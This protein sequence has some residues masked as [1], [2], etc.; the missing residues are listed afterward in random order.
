V[1]QVTSGDRFQSGGLKGRSDESVRRRNQPR[2]TRDL[3]HLGGYISRHHALHGDVCA[4]LSSAA[5][6]GVQF[7]AKFL[8]EFLQNM[9]SNRIIF[10]G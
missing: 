7:T 10:M 8:D 4:M 2:G 1:W 5:V 6:F 3:A 9:V